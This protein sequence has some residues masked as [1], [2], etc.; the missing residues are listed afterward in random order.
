M[1]SFA[2]DPSSPRRGW[3]LPLLD[4]VALVAFTVVGVANHDGGLRADALAR[5][6]GPLL[7]AWFAAARVVGAYRVPGVR[8]LV[9]AWLLAVP[10]GAAGRTLIAGGPWGR[11]FVVFLGVALGFTLLFLLVGR[12][13]AR[14]FG[15]ADAA[16]TTARAAADGEA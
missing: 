15:L 11:G 10:A 1:A 16:A 8:T 4:A 14:A 12:G 2:R 5:V 13:L 9:L 7:V 3:V 6:G